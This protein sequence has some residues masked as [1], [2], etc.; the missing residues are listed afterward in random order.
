MKSE[1]GLSSPGANRGAC[2]VGALINLNGTRTHQLVE[3]GLRILCNLDHRGARGAEEKTG[4]GAG[5]LLQ[6]PHE[7]FHSEIPTLGDFD[8]YGVG[9][10]FVPKDQWKQIAL[11]KLI[12]T[13]C[14]EAAC[15]LI[16]WREVPTDNSDLGRTALLSEP[17]VRQMFVEPLD[18]R[19]PEHLDTQ[20]YVLRRMIE[21]AVK[22]SGICG[23]ELFYVCSLDRRRIVYKGLLTCK[24]LQ[25]YYPDLSN[26]RVK[27]SIVLVHSRFG[28]NTLGAWELAHP[29]RTVVHNGEINTLR[30]NL[31]RMRTREAALE[32]EKFG[33]D[34]ESI[35]PITAEGLSDTAVFDNVLELLLESGRSLPHALR[36]LIP[37]AWNKDKS[38]DARR[39]SFYDY[40]STIIEPWDGP[41]LIAA[42]DGYKVATILDRNGLRPC[43]YCLTRSNIVIM[44]SETGVLDK[45]A[46]EIVFKS[47]LKPGEMFLADTLEKRIVPEQ[48]IF[49][50]LTAHDYLAWLAENRIRLK[51]IVK[52]G[53][54]AEETGDVTPYQRASGYTLES[55]RC[56][57]Q[58][59]AEEGK[60]PIGSMGNDTPLAILSTRH[61]PLFQYFLQLFA[62]VSNPPLDYLREDL[63]TSLESHIGRQ[64]NLL[65]ETPEHCRQLFLDSPVLTHADATAIKNLNRNGIRSCLIDSTYVQGTPLEAALRDLRWRAAQAI[66]D[67]WEI[68]VV[69]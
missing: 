20:L 48:E 10:L 3:D 47:R 30:G 43:R 65:E 46:S 16:S 66:K 8:S 58:P 57:L 2:G 17:A 52:P 62:Q 64:R 25:L 42:T 53:V 13:V 36:M 14:R 61:R 29:Y 33:D 31:N 32:S 22:K 39:R 11:K 37:E 60:D 69:S 44:A 56:L 19:T 67:G 1:H 26:S 68:L 41:A 55:L 28:T 51:D 49:A 7:F 38:M 6:K 15:R 12:T 21:K 50:E 35:K 4:D 54:E 9:Q 34:I 18:P 40:F 63:V 59:M 23:N 5:M 24:Q 27:T 45:P